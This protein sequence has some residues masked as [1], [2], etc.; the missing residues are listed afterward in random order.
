MAGGREQDAGVPSMGAAGGVSPC[1]NSFPIT[2]GPP[3]ITSHIPQ[4]GGQR[5]QCGHSH[6]RSPRDLREGISSLPH[7]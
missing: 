6:A 4:G 5:G 2:T 1:L 3:G 7:C